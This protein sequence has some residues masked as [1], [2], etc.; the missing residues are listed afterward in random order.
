[1]PLPP[2]SGRM[3]DKRR[4]SF[5]RGI[6]HPQTERGKFLV[7]NRKLRPLHFDSESCTRSV[8]V[9]QLCAGSRG[10]AVG[11]VASGQLSSCSEVNEIPISGP[12]QNC[13]SLTRGKNLCYSMAWCPHAVVDLKSIKYIIAFKLREAVNDRF[14]IS[15]ANH[16]N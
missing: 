8:A 14:R 13:A 5:L 15:L 1:M 11:K 2:V 4:M 9:C 7:A 10:C 12:A 3:T 6:K 16:G